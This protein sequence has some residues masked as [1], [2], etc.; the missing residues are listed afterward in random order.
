MIKV[1]FYRTR[2]DGIALY[3]TYSDEGMMMRHESGALYEE[4]INTAGAGGTFV[5]TDQ[6]IEGWEPEEEPM[7]SSRNIASGQ[8]F[9]VGDRLYYSTATIAAGE[10]IVPGTNCTK[11]SLEDVLNEL[12]EE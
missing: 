11:M 2:E 5:E 1:E 12:K 7:E 8:Y 6:P 10:D 9:T 3:R 4:S